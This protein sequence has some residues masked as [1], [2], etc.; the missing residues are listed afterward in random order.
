MDAE[1]LKVMTAAVQASFGPEAKIYIYPDLPRTTLNVL[2]ELLSL[3]YGLGYQIFV[4]EKG[5]AEIF[6]LSGFN[7]SP[8]VICDRYID[9]FYQLRIG[10]SPPF[11]SSAAEH[12]SFQSLL[13][14]VA[15]LALT[16][17]DEDFAVAM[18]LKSLQQRS[19]FLTP[20]PTMSE[21]GTNPMNEMGVV[22]M[23]FGLLHEMG[24]AYFSLEAQKTSSY[25][26]E[27]VAELES[28]VENVIE[29][30]PNST[31]EVKDHYR[32]LS[33]QVG[34]VLSPQTIAEEVW[35]DSFAAKVIFLAGPYLMSST[36]ITTFDKMALAG[37]V[38][39]ASRIISTMEFGRTVA[40]L[41]SE[42]EF[43]FQMVMDKW[44]AYS[45]AF[46][47]RNESIVRTLIDLVGR[48]DDPMPS[49]EDKSRVTE[50]RLELFQK[51]MLKLTVLERSVLL[52]AQTASE[53]SKSGAWKQI[54]EEI[55][56]ETSE[57][58]TS[59]LN[60]NEM[61]A[62]LEV[63][64]TVGASGEALTALRNLVTAS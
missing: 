29:R 22:M 54:L 40:Q 43:I 64:D 6:C 35:V 61:R 23:F 31:A 17:G 37:E 51:L 33:Q 55:T 56:S 16:H 2:Q 46:S 10:L 57:S 47:L 38:V 58:S 18:F 25:G 24:H 30:D 39:T 62:F 7:R 50:R 21:I 8:V 59:V 49:E 13:L 27:L 19:I 9:L 48:T 4:V 20:G 53:V 36:G 42:S 44:N 28:V 26:A 12:L 41:S 1:E 5:P 3:N 63:A 11:D 34:S 60:I 14:A 15:E 52:V 45:V 32:Q